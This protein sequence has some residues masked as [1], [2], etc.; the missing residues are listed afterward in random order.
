[1][2]S[3]KQYTFDNTFWVFRYWSIKG[4]VVFNIYYTRDAQLA[5][6]GPDP[7]LS[8]IYVEVRI[9]QLGFQYEFIAVNNLWIADFDRSFNI[10]LGNNPLG[11]YVLY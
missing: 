1:M 5:D 7:D 8:L 2:P 3:L 11:I 10:D 6:R 9:R 4:S